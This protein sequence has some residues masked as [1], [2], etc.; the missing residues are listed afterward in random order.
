MNDASEPL[1]SAWL[2]E[3]QRWRASIERRI[4]GLEWMA[5]GNDVDSAIQ[6]E[7]E[8][9]QTHLHQQ[10]RIVDE[11]YQRLRAALGLLKEFT[12]RHEQEIPSGHTYSF[13]DLFDKADELL[14]KEQYEK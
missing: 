14:K 11:L 5:G 2:E 4:K 8:H 3:L 9:W 10:D 12:D 6:K 1:S 13:D 7:R